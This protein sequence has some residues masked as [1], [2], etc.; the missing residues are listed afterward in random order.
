MAEIVPKPY[1][2]GDVQED[3]F[4]RRLFGRRVG[5]VG[6][7]DGER[8]LDKRN[9]SGRHFPVVC[10]ANQAQQKGQTER[11]HVAAHECSFG[12]VWQPPA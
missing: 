6:R 3:R 1:P 10:A 7:T 2:A 9:N 4:E 12:R 11:T 8:A 5:S